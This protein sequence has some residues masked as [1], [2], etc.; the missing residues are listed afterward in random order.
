MENFIQA[1]L[2]IITWKQHLRMLQA[3]PAVPIKSQDTV[4]YVSRHKGL[5]NKWH[6]V[7][8]LHSP[9][10]GVTVA[11]YKIRKECYLLRSCLADARRMLLFVVGQVFLPKGEVWLMCHADT[12]CTVGR[13]K[14]T[15]GQKEIFLFKFFLSCHKI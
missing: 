9:D 13:G 8:S 5:Y 1:K 12:Q 2:R 10:L 11:P 15:K 3:G 4:I 6:I 7:E 14:E